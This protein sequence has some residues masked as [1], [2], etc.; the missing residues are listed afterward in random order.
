MREPSGETCGSP[1]RQ[2]EQ[3]LLGDGALFGESSAD[4]RYKREQANDE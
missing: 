3:I 4:S 2:I 1:I